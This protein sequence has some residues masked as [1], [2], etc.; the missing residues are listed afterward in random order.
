[1][2]HLRIVEE[3]ID[4]ANGY[5]NWWGQTPGDMWPCRWDTHIIEGRAPCW[6]I[7]LPDKA[8][9]W[10]TNSE[11]S[12][13]GEGLWVVTGEPPNITVTPSINIGPEIWHGWITAGEMLPA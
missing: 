3:L 11:S 8:W 12:N 2:A 6:V 5:P 10:H 4:P 9:V 7:R 1:M 13:E